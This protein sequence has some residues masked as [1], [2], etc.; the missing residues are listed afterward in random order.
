[1][2]TD[3]RTL[4]SAPADAWKKPKPLPA[5]TYNGQI[6]GREYKTAKSENATPFVQF[7]VKVTGA[8]ADVDPSDLEGI[9]LEKKQ[10]R[11][12]FYLTPDA[13]YRLI[14][15]AAST[16]ISTEGRSTGEIVEDCLQQ[17]VI[18]E[19]VLKPNRNNPEDFYNEVNRMTGKND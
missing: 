8:G 10:L 1:M 11:F 5:G 2:T 12:S 7:T 15:F 3:F 4:T 6:I 19:V 13:G 9:E 14:E 17:E 18:L 16:G